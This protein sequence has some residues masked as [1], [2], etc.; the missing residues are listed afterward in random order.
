MDQEGQDPTFT[1]TGA[2]DGDR[3]V[4]TVTGE[5]DM[6]TAGALFET[7]TPERIT[8]ATIDLR[9]VTF[10]DS[11]AIHTLIRL[12]E[13]YPETLEVIPSERVRRVLDISGLGGQPWLRSH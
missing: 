2:V 13:R 6:S 8:G 3:V 5:V 11:A 10:F 4:V 9:A 1:A 12:A 7:A